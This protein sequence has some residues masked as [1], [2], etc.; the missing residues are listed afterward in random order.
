MEAILVLVGLGLLLAALVAPV[1]AIVALVRSSRV[2]T[3][4]RSAQATIGALETR[5]EALAKRLAAAVHPAAKAGE[6]APA[7]AP[8]SPPA[9]A[10][11]PVPA[12]PPSPPAAPPPAAGAVRAPGPPAR[13]AETPRPTPPPTQPPRPAPPRPEPPQAPPPSFD[14]ESLLG[15]KG[16]AWLGGITIVIASLFFAKWAID[17]GLITPQLR[18]AALVAAGVGSLAWAE[19]SLR[20]G[21]STTANAVSGAGIAILYVAF[22]AGHSL[23]HLFPLALTFALMSLVTVLAGV[24]AVRYDAYFTA[25]L[26]LLG[27]F[28]TPLAL[29]TGV[30]RPVGLFSYILLL[31]VGLLAVALKKRWH[32]LVLLALAGT[33]VIELGWFGKFMAPEKM[34]VGLTA[35]LVFGLLYLLLPVLSKDAED[36]QP[37]LQAGALGG[38]VPFLF[39]VLIAGNR[40]YSAEWPLLFGYVGLLDAALVAVALL[41]GRV[42]LLLGGALAT[43]LTLPLWAGQGLARETLWGPTLAAIALVALLNAP[44][45]LAARVA[46]EALESSS[47]LE[48]AG[49]VGLGGLGLFALVLVARGFGEPPWAF[50]VLLAALFGLLVER[51]GEERIPGVAAVGGIACAV[52]V[53]IWFFRNA[54]GETLLRNL[55]VG[56]LLTLALSLVAA[57]RSRAP[58][59]A[60]EDE[61]AVVGAN[62]VFLAGLFG[63]LGSAERGGDPWPLFAALGVSMV[64]L[65]ASVLRRDWTPLLPVGL[66]VS[67]L[68][69]VVWQ[70]SYFHPT[71]VGVVLPLYAAFFLAFLALPFLVP[72]PVRS[73]WRGRPLPWLT[74]ALSGPAFF[75]AL[76]QA[77]VAVWG[78]AWIG[79][80]PVV[81]AGLTVAALSGVARRFTASPADAGGQHLRLRYLALFA[82]IALGFVALAIPLQL[83]RQWITLGWALEAAAVLWLFSRLPHPG[84]KLFGALLYAFVGARLLLNPEV[85]RYQERGFP[86]VNWLLYTYG[87]SALCCFA[88]AWFLRRAGDTTRVGPAAAFLGLLLVF[89]LVN[90]EIVDFFSTGPYAEFAMRR[91]LERDLTM[92]VAWG[93]YAM[94]LLVI[95]LLREVRALRMISL[96]FLLLTVAKVFLYDLANLTGLYRILSFL[97]LGV[98]LILVSLLYQRFVSAR[99][100][101]K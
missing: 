31:N 99:E 74:S 70:E 38:T 52:L 100:E 24:L 61:A 43:A 72:A 85:L 89:W 54:A 39:A 92:S 20:R 29:S 101:A 81:Q 17:Q 37:L 88:G 47:L 46:P 23:Y 1:L 45:R 28:A 8:V 10:P 21:Y 69:A 75:L 40:A 91:Q 71:D 42:P 18:I 77:I 62:L 57:L 56:L 60:D 9:P 48:A 44:K 82:A 55:A 68:F 76:H 78:K 11:T 30:D 64:L 34:L 83:D 15:L 79:A 53:Q 50:V 6:A 41:R 16:A 90:L 63:C 32:G 65:V 14:W 87:V 49:L 98:S 95:G 25:I 2:Q 51:T 12:A 27:G 4:L 93:L 13:G 96:G 86:I 58:V 19:L 7:A 73:L 26:G 97:G 66:A 22:F 59:N 67:A 3:D 94:V 5:V 84:L 35:F 33:F 36:S 80:L